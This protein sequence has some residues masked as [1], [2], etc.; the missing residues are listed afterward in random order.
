MNASRQALQKRQVENMNKQEEFEW[1]CYRAIDIIKRIKNEET[2]ERYIDIHKAFDMAI[3]ALKEIQ[4]YR[5]L[6][7]VEDFKRAKKNERDAI[8]FAE[9]MKEKAD[10]NNWN[11]PYGVSF[12]VID[13]LLN[14]MGVS[15]A[16]SEVYK[17]EN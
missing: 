11:K 2:H 10:I 17:K 3:Q 9:K 14:E 4:Q 1:E 6:G 5:A 7:T 12:E 15:D 13:E 8:E 16:Y